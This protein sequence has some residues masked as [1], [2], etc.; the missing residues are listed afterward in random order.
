MTPVATWRPC[1]RSDLT[2]QRAGQDTLLYDPVADAVHVL[3]RT[4][5]AIWELCDGQCTLDDMATRL[6]EGFAS[7]PDQ[8]VHGD[9]V[10]AVLAQNG[11][12]A[13]PLPSLSGRE[14]ANG[15]D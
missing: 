5:W 6:Q 8:D 4:A 9:I 14:V 1:R 11:L 3:N 15:P 13:I 10:L 12:I 7:L 2:I